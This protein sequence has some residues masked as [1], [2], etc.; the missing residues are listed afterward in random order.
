MRKLHIQPGAAAIERRIGPSRSIVTRLASIEYTII[1]RTG[2]EIDR[3]EG[4]HRNGGLVLSRF[5]AGLGA[6]R[7]DRIA[8]DLID[9]RPR[10]VVCIEFADEGLAQRGERRVE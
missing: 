5:T 7:D 4:I 9:V 8:V 2:D 6:G 1:V 3:V 10:R